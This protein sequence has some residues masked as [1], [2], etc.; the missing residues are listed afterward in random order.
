MSSFIPVIGSL[1][2]FS[3]ELTVWSRSVGNLL[4]KF[5]YVSCNRFPVTMPTDKQT[6]KQSHSTEN[7]TSDG[8][9]QQ[10][11]ALGDSILP[12]PIFFVETS[13]KSDRNWNPDWS[14]SRCLPACSKNVMDSFPRRYQWFHRVRWKVADESKRNANKSQKMPSAIL[15]VVKKWTGLVS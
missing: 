15:R 4:L 7:Y 11:D 5:H 12:T 14:G 8:A 2:K 9:K 10:Q 3:P 1:A 13:T 6:N